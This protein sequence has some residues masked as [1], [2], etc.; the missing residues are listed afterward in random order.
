MIAP[1]VHS[2]TV[3][4]PFESKDCSIGDVLKTQLGQF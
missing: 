1:S 2:T 4:N 3:L